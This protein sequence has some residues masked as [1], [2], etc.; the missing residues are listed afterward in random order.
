LVNGSL[1]EKQE[2]AFKKAIEK[3]FKGII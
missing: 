3:G 1:E 2:E